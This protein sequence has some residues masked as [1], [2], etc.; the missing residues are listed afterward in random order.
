[1]ALEKVARKQGS[2]CSVVTVAE[3]Y[4]ET[5]PAALRGLE[6]MG[7]HGIVVIA[8][9]VSAAAAVRTCQ[10]R[11]PLVLI[12]AGEESAPGLLAYGENQELGARIATQHLLRL[13]HT[14]I[15]HVAGSQDWFDGRA[16]LR[17]WSSEMQEAGLNSDR[18][19]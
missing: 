13:G 17:G 14:D 4:E 8:P 11:V 3:P 10:V 15:L 9:L 2:N 6:E 7:V 16:R 5:V 18:W 1:M 12:A 19:F